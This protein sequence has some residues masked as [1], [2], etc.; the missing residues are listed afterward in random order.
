MLAWIVK[1]KDDGEFIIIKC[2]NTTGSHGLMDRVVASD[3]NLTNQGTKMLP[4]LNIV[5]YI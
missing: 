5:A 4:K 1:M 2:Q 3:T